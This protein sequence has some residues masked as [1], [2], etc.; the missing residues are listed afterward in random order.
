MRFRYVQGDN[1]GQRRVLFGQ[2]KPGD[3]RAICRNDA[4]RAGNR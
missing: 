1:V 4:I 3:A 2:D